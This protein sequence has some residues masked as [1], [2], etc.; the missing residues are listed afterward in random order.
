MY[1]IFRAKVYFATSALIATH[2]RDSGGT[3]R[4]H[5]HWQFDYDSIADADRYF[6]KRFGKSDSSP[7]TT[8]INSATNTTN[9]FAY[10]L[11]TFIG[12]GTYKYWLEPAEGAMNADTTAKPKQEVKTKDL[13]YYKANNHVT[14]VENATAGTTG[15]TIT[16]LRWKAGFSGVYEYNTNGFNTPKYVGPDPPEG[17]P[18]TGWTWS[19]SGTGSE[20]NL[21][22]AGSVRRKK[23]A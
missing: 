2:D 4:V 22:P 8:R 11:T 1:R 20:A 7:K 5:A 23:G 12:T 21:D 17:S 19:E 9:C 15:N 10:A 3:N 13:L 14:G 16:K 18:P 6:D